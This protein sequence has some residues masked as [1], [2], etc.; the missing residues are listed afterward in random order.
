[1][2][3]HPEI[4]TREKLIIRRRQAKEIIKKFTGKNWEEYNKKVFIQKGIGDGRTENVYNWIDIECRI[5]VTINTILKK[6]DRK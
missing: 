1:M 5:I 3:N 4:T 6:N 2:K